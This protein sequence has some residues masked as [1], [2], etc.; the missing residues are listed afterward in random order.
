MAASLNA[1]K[2]LRDRQFAKT[3][4]DIAAAKAEA[5][6]RVAQAQTELKGGIRT[7]RATVD[8]QVAK[9][10]KRIDELGQTV[11]KNKIAQAKVNANT[12]AEMKRMIALGNKRY[13]QHLKHDAELHSLIKK[14][15]AATDARMDAMAAKYTNE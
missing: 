12:A 15:K 4:K 13:K 3:V 9:T 2:A 10:N 6:A 1:E 7:L 11:T 14:N 5:K 8:E